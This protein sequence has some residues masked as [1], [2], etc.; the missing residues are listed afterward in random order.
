MKRLILFAA[1]VALAVVPSSALANP[2]NPQDWAGWQ[3]QHSDNLASP[4]YTPHRSMSSS[5]WSHPVTDPAYRWSIQHHR[6]DRPPRRTRN[7]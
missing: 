5:T 2:T 6:Q 1:A 4:N 3:N 7:P